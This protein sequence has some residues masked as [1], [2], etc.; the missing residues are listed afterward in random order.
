MDFSRYAGTESKSPLIPAKT[1]AWIWIN[2]RGLKVSQAGGR[3][4]DIEA[5]VDDHTPAGH[6][7]SR[8]KLFLKV[9]DPTWAQNS[10]AAKEMG[11]IT[12]TRMLESG[13]NAG[14]HNLAGYHVSEDYRE[15][16]QIRVAAL[17]GVEPGKDGYD[18]KNRIDEWLTPNPTSKSGHKLWDPLI[19][20]LYLADQRKTPAPAVPSAAS[21]GTQPQ[22]PT[23]P[24]APMTPPAPAQGSMPWGAAGSFNQPPAGNQPTPVAPP[25]A[26]G[27]PSATAAT[28]TS[29]AAASPSNPLPPAWL[30]AGNAPG[31]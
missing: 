5:V 13:R 17:I 23:A 1:L 10:E 26:P 9:M 22:A 12:V 19:R 8:R 31:R 15:L 20:G 24:A 14:P 2:L 4:L 29:V 30:A 18:D 3:Y 28:P 7:F 16:N 25:A 11:S 6:P 21:F 27:S